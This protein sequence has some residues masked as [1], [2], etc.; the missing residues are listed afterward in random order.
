MPSW[1]RIAWY[2]GTALGGAGLAVAIGYRVLGA[3][4]G[5]GTIGGLG[6]VMLGIAPMY[7]VAVWLMHERPEHPQARRMLLMSSALAVNAGMEIPV[8]QA[9]EANGPGRWF[10]WANLVYQYTGVAALIAA[11]LLLASFPDGV[12]ERTWQRWALNAVWAHLALPP[13]LLLTRPN[14]VID[15]YLLDPAPVVP[16]PLAVAWLQPLGGL[17]ANLYLSYYGALVLIT[18][19]F[20]R[21]VQADAGQRARMRLLMYATIGLVVAT[22]LLT[23]L[24]NRFPEPPAWVQLVRG[25][26]VVFLLMVP[27]SV[28]IGILRHRLYD[29][30][31]AVRRSVT[32]GVLSLGIAAVYIGLSV[33]PG[34][35]LGDQIP[36]EVA[37]VLTIAAAAVFQ[38]LR[39][40]LERLA[41][42]LVFGE[43]VNR[44]ELVTRF[45][46]GLE[47]TVELADL[48][49]RL[50]ET[51]HK[52]LDA[53]WVRVTLPSARAVAGHPEGEPELTVPLERAGSTIG[54]IECGPKEG[55]YSAADRELLATLA[56]QAATAIANVQLTARL[57]E[58]VDELATSRTRIVAAQDDERRRIERDIH[59]GAQQQVVALIMKMRLARNQVGRGEREAAEVLDELQSDTRELLADLR[60]LAH[61][62]HPPVLSDRGLVAAVEARADRLPLAVTVHASPGLREQRLG[63]EVEGA[64][65]F[66]VCEALTNVVK[67]SAAA[68]ARVSLA[69][70][71]GRLEVEVCDS[72]VGLGAGN[73]QGL[74]NLRDRVEA[75]GGRLSVSG[76]PGAGTRVHADLPTGA[77]RG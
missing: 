37:V 48:L 24:E 23:V 69:A 77:S 71:D 28:V 74:T 18:V 54:V 47:Q 56:G 57:A 7:G 49:P 59:D 67:H 8:R 52:G 22:A 58:Q 12:V 66:V 72:G 53:G 55:G 19:L 65:Y 6:W 32:F 33:A 31:V 1:P 21:F 27:V 40:R 44:Y 62:I 29:I 36:V 25:A 64:A 41:D 9:F 20:V 10:W 5:H 75:L 45:G 11:V 17:L 76:E 68:S 51:V 14:L 16:S 38:P 73:G 42:R 50:T 4:G 35:A 60:E 13:L 30:D 26:S 70:V 46:A 34:L 63:T 61:G 15:A 2:A 43:R 39:R 3:P